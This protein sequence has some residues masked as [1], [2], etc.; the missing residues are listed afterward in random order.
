M[1]VM[2]VKHPH[3]PGAKAKNVDSLTYEAIKSRGKVAGTGPARRNQSVTAADSTPEPELERDDAATLAELTG[4]RHAAP[5][6]EVVADPALGA[7]FAYVALRA[8]SGSHTFA[9]NCIFFECSITAS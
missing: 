7:G 6:A 4:D 5:V 1:L 9:R 8:R 3:H 2:L